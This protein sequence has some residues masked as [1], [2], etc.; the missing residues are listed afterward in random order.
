[1]LTACNMRLDN[2][3]PTLLLLLLLLPN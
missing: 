3:A 2:P 1:M